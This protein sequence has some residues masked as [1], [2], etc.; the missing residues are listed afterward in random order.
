M[1]RSRACGGMLLTSVPSIRM[2]PLVGT[3]RP[4]INRSTVLLPLPDGPTSTSNSPCATSRS[5]S[6][7]AAT[8][9][10]NRLPILCNEIDAMSSLDRAGGESGDD[11]ALSDEHQ[12]G[13]R[14]R[15]DE[16]ARENL[17]SG[18]LILPAKE[19]NRHRHGVTLGPE[20]KTEREQKLVPAVQERQDRGRRQPW[21]GQRQHDR[22]QGSKPAGAIH[23][24]R[25]FELARKLPEE[26]D[27]EPDREWQCKGQV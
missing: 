1:A 10:G 5:T 14:Q 15:R 26:A 23:Q 24:R 25:L 19:R 9:P 11:P 17:S 8:P 13:N 3:S 16:R 20:R 4:A 22:P 7:S 12:R 18:H 6:L 27:E 2:R 21:P